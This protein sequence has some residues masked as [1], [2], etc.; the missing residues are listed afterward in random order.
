MDDDKFYAVSMNDDGEWDISV[1]DTWDDIV[2][3]YDL[4]SPEDYNEPPYEKFKTMVDDY[5]PGVMV[6]KGKLVMP[7][8]IQVKT[9]FTYKIK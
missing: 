5:N 9:E 4:N 8:P 6:I 2:K 7:E 3:M 1:F